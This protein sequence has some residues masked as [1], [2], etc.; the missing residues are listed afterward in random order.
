[1][2]S[3]RLTKP[4]ALAA[5]ATIITG[6]A[7]AAGSAASSPS[8]HQTLAAQGDTYR[9]GNLGTLSVSARRGVLANDNGGDDLQI[10]S[11]TDPANG[12]LTLNPDGSFGY[13]PQD[14]FTGDDT[15]T[16]T[17]SNAVQLYSTDLPALGQFGGVSLSGGAFGSSLYPDP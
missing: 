6:V 15:F 13:V 11:H 5:A 7:V 14:G 16:Y 1:M 3:Y 17:I 2:M 8:N 4:R 12:S 10:V 9:A